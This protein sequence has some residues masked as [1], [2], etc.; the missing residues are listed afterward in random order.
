MKFTKTFFE[1]IINFWTFLEFNREKRM[2]NKIENL[3][4]HHFVILNETNDYNNSID[5]E[6]VNLIRKIDG[7]IYYSNQKNGNRGEIAEFE[8]EI[9]KKK[10][11]KDQFNEFDRGLKKIFSTFSRKEIIKNVTKKNN[12]QIQ[13][14]KINNKLY[15]KKIYLIVIMQISFIIFLLIL[16]IGIPIIIIISIIKLIMQLI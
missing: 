8:C 9:C 11:E 7:S 4:S 2:R 14:I 16:F 5:I 6:I 15:K 12:L 10:F 1:G 13:A 3:C